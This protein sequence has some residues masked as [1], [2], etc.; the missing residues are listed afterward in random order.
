MPRDVEI[1]LEERTREKSRVALTACDSRFLAFAGE[2]LICP[3]LLT[4]TG[5]YWLT[6][7]RR[8]NPKA[9]LCDNLEG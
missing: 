6:N 8:V 7:I 9:V 3:A 4:S 1:L 2:H 5:T